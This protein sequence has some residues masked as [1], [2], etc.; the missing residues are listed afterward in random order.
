[1]TR[2]AHLTHAPIGSTAG[3]RRELAFAVTVLW[4]VENRLRVAFELRILLTANGY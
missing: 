3:Y 4:K 1:M 2:L